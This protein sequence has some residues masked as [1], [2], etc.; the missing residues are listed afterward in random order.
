MKILIQLFSKHVTDEQNNDYETNTILI[1]WELPII[2]RTY[3]AFDCDEI[4]ADKLP[5]HYYGLQWE[6]DM[7]SYVKVNGVVC[8][9][10][11]LD[12]N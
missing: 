1:D 6:V 8:P 12:G 7:V 10:I 3:E 9:K 11:Y 2:P 4:I 5:E